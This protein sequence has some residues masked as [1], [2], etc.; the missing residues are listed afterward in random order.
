MTARAGVLSIGLLVVFLL[1]LGTKYSG[2][3]AF[4]GIGIGAVVVGYLSERCALTLLFGSWLLPYVGGLPITFGY[5]LIAAMA[6][7]CF[8]RV[9][10][11][12]HRM[13]RPF[14]FLSLGTLILA[15]ALYPFTQAINL[16]YLGAAI[17]LAWEVVCLILR[18]RL[19]AEDIRFSFSVALGATV[20]V[21]LL[22]NL[23]L[24]LSSP[25]W[26]PSHTAFAVLGRLTVSVFDELIVA[27]YLTALFAVSLY[28]QS[29]RPVWSDV[30]LLVLLLCIFVTGSRA[31]LLLAGGLLALGIV[32]SPHAGP[33]TP[34]RSKAIRVLLIGCCGLVILAAVG[35]VRL[36]TFER[37]AQ[38]ASLS[39]GRAD[40]VRWAL[41]TLD[42]VPIEP[43][44]PGEYLRGGP[45]LVPHFAPVAAAILL[46]L[47]LACW[48]IALLSIPVVDL[49]QGARLTTDLK[50]SAA[51]VCLLALVLVTP[52]IVDRGLYSLAGV[53]FAC[54]RGPSLVCRKAAQASEGSV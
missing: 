31:A 38:E 6:P 48:V 5:V 25:Y 1:A 44:D 29:D 22:A 28:A 35:G 4:L 23:V 16:I 37:F 7:Y 43:V 21:P 24:S 42:Q 10:E 13:S 19:N 11:D 46:G 9:H 51:Y 39:S 20:V 27:G 41:P 32:A 30:W 15:C 54:S 17:L 12:V 49:L 53:W 36:T 33:T 50:L 47:P 45:P 14:V 8:V 34:V 52:H 40:S 18:G 26:F 3:P 2:H